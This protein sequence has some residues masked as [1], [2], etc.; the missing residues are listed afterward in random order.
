FPY[1]QPNV[2]PVDTIA[3]DVRG[4]FPPRQPP[5][6]QPNVAPVDTIVPDARGGSL[7]QQIL[8]GQASIAPFDTIVPNANGGFFLRQTPHGQTSFAPVNAT[9]GISGSYQPRLPHATTTGAYSNSYL[10]S[11]VDHGRQL[12]VPHN[13][14]AGVHTDAN[15][16][17]YA[18]YGG[19][20]ATQIGATCGPGNSPQANQNIPVSANGGLYRQPDTSGGHITGG[21]PALPAP[22]MIGPLDA[23][24]QEHFVQGS[25][26][27][28]LPVNNSQTCP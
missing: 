21:S 19:S 7:P 22:P 11:G 25:V 27:G 17:S 18:N 12:P 13:L 16:P 15:L 10:P 9:D 20:F 26:N 4:G 6:G 23:V 2:A 24:A 14:V 5:Y 28:R 8:C 1:G 3:P